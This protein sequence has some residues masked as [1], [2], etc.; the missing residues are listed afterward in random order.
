MKKL[1]T[2]EFIERARKVHGD[3]YDYSKVEYK[4]N[5]IRVCIV[6]PIH[7]E[8]WQTP[9]THLDGHGC[10]ECK[11]EKLRQLETKPWELLCEE[12]N[13]VHK[14]KYQYDNTLY[15]NSHSTINITCPIHGV[16]P[17]RVYAHLQG[18][19]CPF[20]VHQSFKDTL[21][22]FIEKARKVHG[23][24]Y[25][26]SKVEYKGKDVKVIII[27]PIHGEFLQTPHNHING[28]GCPKCN[29]SKLEKNVR[30]FLE[31]NKIDYVYQYRD[32]KKLGLQTLDFYLTKLNIGLECQGIQH[33][34]HV[35]FSRSIDIDKLFHDV[36]E[37]DNLKI[38]KCKE[39]GI[40]LIH[41]NPFEK[42]FG[43]YENEVHNVEELEKMLK[44][45]SY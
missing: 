5:K 3:L 23:D 21:E 17:M 25:D 22:N 31:A 35:C 39:N 20:C 40:K 10:P 34:E 29:S 44:L 32:R 14:N 27:C 33:F 9:N 15:V 13:N 16:F 11:K 4:G 12:M 36:Q 42:Y 6:C 38:Q 28:Q 18:Q 24:K 37:R 7:G 19:E 45:N 30:Q 41:Y 26:Y 1:T 2:E 8:F 43:T